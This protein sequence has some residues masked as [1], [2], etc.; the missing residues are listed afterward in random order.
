MITARSTRSNR[1]LRFAASLAVAT[2][3]LVSCSSDDDSADTTTPT[4]AGNSSENDSLFCQDVA[5]VTDF[6]TA[7]AMSTLEA[8][9]PT[10]IKGDITT[11]KDHLEKAEADGL[12][13]DEINAGLGEVTDEAGNV[14]RFIGSE[15][16]I[17][18]GAV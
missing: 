16:G 8:N 14:I 3:L 12:S 18:L 7:E 2:A 17:D 5:K 15:C 4:E 9:A 6:Q 13:K 11:L 10:A 1:P